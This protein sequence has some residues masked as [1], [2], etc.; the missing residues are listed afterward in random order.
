MYTYEYEKVF[1]KGGLVMNR[2]VDHQEIINNRA[3]DGWRYVGFIP[4]AQSGQGAIGE[5]DLVF[6][7]E[8][9]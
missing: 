8:V 3:R 5:M 2:T 9:P 6:E 1:V 7:K 4:T